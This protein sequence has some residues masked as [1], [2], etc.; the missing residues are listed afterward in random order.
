[1]K[2]SVLQCLPL[3]PGNG[4]KREELQ[5][6]IFKALGELEELV[7]HDVGVRDAFVSLKANGQG[8]RFLQIH[9]VPSLRYKR[10]LQFR[11]L[12]RRIN[13]TIAPR[14]EDPLVKIQVMRMR[15]K[16]NFHASSLD[17]PLL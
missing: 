16:K 14:I 1:M 5:L 6:Q 13:T 8:E 10:N 7:R 12:E 9:V 17:P 11:E 2:P 15:S 4:R 3:F